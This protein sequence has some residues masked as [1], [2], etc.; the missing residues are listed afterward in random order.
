MY[1]TINLF[2][3]QKCIDELILILISLIRAKYYLKLWK[4]NNY[5]ISRPQTIQPTSTKSCYEEEDSKGYMNA[6]LMSWEHSHHSDPN[7]TFEFVKRKS[8]ST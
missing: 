2:F 4:L 7:I 8:P 1:R 5:S 6:E 3:I